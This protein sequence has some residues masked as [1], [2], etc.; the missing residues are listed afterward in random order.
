MSR[1]ITFSRTFQKS[2]LRAGEPTY[3]VEKIYKCLYVMKCVPPELISTFNYGIMNDVFI[4]PKSHTIR[5]G[6]RFKVGDK[7]S[8]RVWIGKPYC[9]KQIVIAPDIEVKKVWDFKLKPSLWWDE[10][11]FYI[12]DKWCDSKMLVEV[13]KNDGLEITDFLRWFLGNN[14][15]DTKRNPFDGQI[16]CWNENINY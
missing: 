6:H 9:S 13:A 7:F 3:F 14:S 12:N 11:E 16:I 1:V 15:A 10:C 4:A 5:S 8:P 2:H